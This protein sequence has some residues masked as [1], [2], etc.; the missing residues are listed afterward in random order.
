MITIKKVFFEDK[1]RQKLSYH[2][3]SKYQ[4]LY[5]VYP[6]RFLLFCS[7]FCFCLHSC[8]LFWVLLSLFSFATYMLLI[9]LFWTIKYHVYY[10]SINVYFR[11]TIVRYDIYVPLNPIICGCKGLFSSD[12]KRNITSGQE[13]IPFDSLWYFD[14]K[15]YKNEWRF[16]PLK[17]SVSRICDIFRVYTMLDY[18]VLHNHDLHLTHM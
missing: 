7:V 5:F 6:V 10:A 9:M 1:V 18:S 12:F 15:F 11:F 14:S 13:N 8:F 16:S 3:L 4:P 2:V 17:S